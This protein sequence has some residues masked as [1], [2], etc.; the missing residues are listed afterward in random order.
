MAPIYT[1]KTSP[2]GLLISHYKAPFTSTD[3]PSNP[4]S[5]DFT[6]MTF[7]YDTTAEEAAFALKEHIIGKNGTSWAIPLSDI[8][9]Y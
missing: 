2:T 4:A 5:S 1:N 3:K 8:E 7:A 6:V 9:I